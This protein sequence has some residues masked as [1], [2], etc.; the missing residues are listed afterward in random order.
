[1]PSGPDS[2]KAASKPRK[3]K[4]SD[5]LFGF[6]DATQAKLKVVLEDL[7]LFDP[8]AKPPN[9]SGKSVKPKEATAKFRAGEVTA[10]V[11]AFADASTIKFRALLHGSK[12]DLMDDEETDSDSQETGK[13]AAPEPWTLPESKLTQQERKLKQQFLHK[14]ASKSKDSRPTKA[15][16]GTH[17]K[18]EKAN[19]IAQW[20]R[21]HKLKLAI[22]GLAVGLLFVEWQLG[23]SGVA[24]FLVNNGIE[25]LS[26]GHPDDA[27][28]IS[29]GGMFIGRRAIL[30]KHL[31]ITPR[32]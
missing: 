32:L 25:Q 18:P 23:H 27:L 28:T 7:D 29:A 8:S 15:R 1:M 30:R 11:M 5:L 17:S 21:A 24:Q 12:P 2:G 22:S 3:Q 10:K 13:S 9:L 14:A 31:K 19:P 6:G 4:K 26:H 16:T 20:I